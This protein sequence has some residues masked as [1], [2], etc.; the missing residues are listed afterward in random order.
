MAQ[1]PSQQIQVIPQ[2][3]PSTQHQYVSQ[4]IIP[5]NVALQPGSIGTTALQSLGSASGVSLQLQ[6]KQAMDSKTNC[7]QNT[8]SFQNA[9]LLQPKGP[10]SAVQ[11]HIHLK[12]LPARTPLASQASGS[13]YNH[14]QLI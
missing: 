12:Q 14:P 1:A 4:I 10:F 2:H 13:I 6:A 3:L 9:V 7:I 5:G 8:Q 11:N